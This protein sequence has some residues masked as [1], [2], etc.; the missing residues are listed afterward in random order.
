MTDS[1]DFNPV[2]RLQVHWPAFSPKK[3]AYDARHSVDQNTFQGFDLNGA[4]ELIQTSDTTTGTSTGDAPR[5]RKPTLPALTGMRTILAVNIVFFHFT[6]PH[7]KWLYPVINSSFVFVGFFFLLSGFVLAYNYADRP[8]LDKGKFYL[9]RFARLYPVY[10]VSLAISLKMLQAEWHV[11]SHEEFWRGLILTPMLMQGWNQS[12][13]TFWNTVAWTLSAEVALYL[14]FPYL[15]KLLPWPK[16]A[17]RLAVMVIAVWMIGLVPHTIYL[18]TNPDH[19]PGPADR[20]SYGPWL[21]TLKYTPMAYLCIFISGMALGKLQSVVRL[22]HG[23]RLWTAAGSLLALVVFFASLVGHTSYVLLHGGLLVPLFSLLVLGLSGE[24]W[25]ASVFSWKPIVLLGETTFCLYLLH[26]NTMNL[27]RD[28]RVPQRL[29]IGML[30]P[31]IS[32]FA[33]LA[34]AFAAT[35]WVEQPA[36][37]WILARAGSRAKAA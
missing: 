7:M 11:R 20:Y 35:Y 30:D 21:R 9:A 4:T 33:V 23:Q 13:A 16:T 29:G 37:K 5:S 34:V 17:S 6:P 27:L 8:E 25:I 32:Y 22:S 15:V 31:W 12:L 26:F 18:L 2:G 10:L 36:R 3:S 24:H 19:L 28:Y 14:A 1:S